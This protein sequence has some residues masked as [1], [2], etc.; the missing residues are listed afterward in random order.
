[1]QKHWSPSKVGNVASQLVR[2]DSDEMIQGKHKL[3]SDQKHAKEDLLVS[4]LFHS[5]CSD[6]LQQANKYLCLAK[7]SQRWLIT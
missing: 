6:I 2:A 5:L 7:Q 1:M 3:T 4:P